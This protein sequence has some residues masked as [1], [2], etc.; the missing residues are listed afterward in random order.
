M[1]VWFTAGAD[2]SVAELAD[3]ICAAQM[4]K[5]A[6]A[7]LPEEKVTFWFFIP[8]GFK[9]FFQIH[10]GFSSQFWFFF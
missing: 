4:S 7:V 6:D 3:F 10:Y 2:A 8:C 9:I 5:A 1:S